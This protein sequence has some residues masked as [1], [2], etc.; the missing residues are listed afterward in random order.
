MH[1]P[2]KTINFLKK[3]RWSYK[4]IILPYFINFLLFV[5]V[6]YS[7]FTFFSG[8]LLSISLLQAI[9]AYLT[10]IVSGTLLIVTFLV[11]AY[12]IFLI[13]SIVASPFNGLLVKKILHQEVLLNI[14][15]KTNI[16]SIF[17]ELKRSSSFEILKLILIVLIFLAGLIFPLIPIIGVAIA[18]LLNY[19]GNTYLTLVDF[20]DPALSNMGIGVSD[21]FKYVR[22]N[23][24]KNKSLFIGTL[25][26]TFIPLV[27]I[28]FIPFAVISAT[29]TYINKKKSITTSP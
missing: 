5:F 14:E 23:L 6:W 9:P 18:F 21:R 17:A 26:L 20:Y 13:S 4:Y 22:K 16:Y 24:L 29:L 1:K 7:I 25:F 2:L 12:F 27:N 19:L 15:E 11:C 28:V 8:L 3:N 10:F